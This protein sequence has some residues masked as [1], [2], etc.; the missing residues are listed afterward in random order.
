MP[1]QP[2]DRRGLDIDGVDQNDLRVLRFRF[3]SQ[4]GSKR[5]VL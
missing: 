1:P 2:V 3:C 4:L 5:T